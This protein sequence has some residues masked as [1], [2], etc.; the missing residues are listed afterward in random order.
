MF[1]GVRVGLICSLFVGLWPE[2]GGSSRVRRSSKLQ[3]D[4]ALACRSTC[5]TNKNQM[6]G[7]GKE[8][9][10]ALVVLLRFIGALLVGWVCASVWMYSGEVSPKK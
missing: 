1:A 2:Y 9:A 5:K 4:K 7:K 8:L 6:R 3:Q 10:A